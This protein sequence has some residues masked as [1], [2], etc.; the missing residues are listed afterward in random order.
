MDPQ[1]Q[2]FTFLID[3]TLPEMQDDVKAMLAEA[4]KKQAAGTFDQAA[5][6]DFAAKLAPKL[7]PDKVT[8]VQEAMAKFASRLKK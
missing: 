8:E 2:F 5:F 4:F 6:K 7:L 1:K 3:R